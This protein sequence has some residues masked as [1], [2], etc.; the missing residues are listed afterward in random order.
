MTMRGLVILASS[1][2][3]LLK[4]AIP[5]AG[6]IEDRFLVADQPD[7]LYI[8]VQPSV[9]SQLTNGNVAACSQVAATLYTLVKPQLD[10]RIVLGT[11]R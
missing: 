10:L 2:T 6:W 5:L 1:P 8:I 9:R 7:P 4:K 3:F 11:S